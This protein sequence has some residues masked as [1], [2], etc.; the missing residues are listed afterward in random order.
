MKHQF[1]KLFLG[2]LVAAIFLTI[3]IFIGIYMQKST[4]PIEIDYKIRYSELLN[5]FTTIMVGFYVGYILKNQF[6]N[7]KVVKGY[8]LEDIKKVSADIVTIK[9]YCYSC[10]NAH[11]YTEEQRKEI[12]AKMNLLDKKITVFSDFFNDCF[13]E[14]HK[15]IDQT[16]VKSFNCFNKKITGDGFYDEQ[17]TGAYFDEI[18]GEGA[19]FEGVLRKLTLTIINDI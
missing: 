3:G 14:K 12:N 4:P 17:I 2:M 13:K 9:E 8:L 7:N 11:C 16:L 1:M 5:W 15:E 6:E 19:K 10:K 18:M